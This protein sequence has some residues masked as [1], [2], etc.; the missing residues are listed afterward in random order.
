MKSVMQHQFSQVPKANI[1]R[2]SFNRSHGYK[3]TF[4]AGL[5]IPIFCDEALPG[6]SFNLRMTAFARL[7]TPFN[8]IMDNMY[9]STFFFAV[10][11]RLIWDNWQK[12][13]GEQENPGDSTDYL[14][15]QVALTNTDTVVGSIWDYFGLP[16]TPGNINV[17]AFWSRAYNLI[18]NEWFRDENLID[19]AVVDKDDGPDDPAD[20]VLLVMIVTGKH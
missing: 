3:T 19:S 17:S 15:P 20:Y 11:I 10:P 9:L 6:D 8:P 16:L 12:F 7:A 13:N 18:Y 2:S 4:D 5:L 1:E 14:V